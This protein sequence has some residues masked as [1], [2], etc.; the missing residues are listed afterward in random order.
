M[1]AFRYF[2][3][4]ALMF[5]GVGCASVS[6]RQNA[7]I[8]KGIYAEHAAMT[9][10]RF[11]DA[12]EYNDQLIRLVP[13]PKQPQVVHSFTTQG[14]T[15]A[16]L[17]SAFQGFPAL[18]AG[19]TL[20]STALGQDK[21]LQGDVEA[22]NKALGVFSKE[23]DGVVRAVDA[24]AVKEPGIWRWAGWLSLPLLAV[25]AVCLCVLFPP[26]IPFVVAAVRFAVHLA[27]AFFRA[28]GRAIGELFKK[29]NPPS[30]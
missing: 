16:V 9:A 18:T 5:A 19:S 1:K 10:G 11:D 2:V 27:G 29:G 13:P 24:A 4:S 12:Q 6:Q 25:V 8:S 17:P 14:K 22:D 23:T 15:Y 28:A 7:A 21:T 26:A 20:F 3:L 30:G